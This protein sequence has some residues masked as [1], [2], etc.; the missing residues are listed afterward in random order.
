MHSF[1]PCIPVVSVLASLRTARPFPGGI[2]DEVGWGPGQFGLVPHC[3][4]TMLAAVGLGT[5]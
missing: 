3:L 1:L 2:Q 4:E 5:I